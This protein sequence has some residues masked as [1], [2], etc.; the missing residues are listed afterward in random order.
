MTPDI[1]N[2]ITSLPLHLFVK[3]G[4]NVPIRTESSW[5][6]E[7][8]EILERANWLCDKVITEPEKLLKEMPAFLSEGYGGQ[9]AIYSCAILSAALL[10]ISR[11]YPEEKLLCLNRL[12]KLV[13]VTMSPEIRH[14]DT[15]AWKK[16]ALET[17]QG[18]RGHMTYLSLL[19]WTISNYKLTGGYST[20]FDELFQGCCEALSRR[21]RAGKNLCLPSFPN[22]IIFFPDMLVT[23]VALHHHD[24][25]YGDCYNETVERWLEKAKTEWIHPNTGLLLAKLNKKSVGQVPRGS[26]SALNTYY[27]SLIDPDFANQQYGR[28]MQTFAKEDLVAGKTVFGIKEYLR[29]SPAMTFDYDAGPIIS[30]FSPSGT[31]WAIGSATFSMTGR[32]EVACCVRA[33][34]QAA[35]YGAKGN[36]TICWLNSPWSAR[37]WCWP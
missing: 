37:L 11:L 16:D 23:I 28:M 15:I 36:D 22:G 34:W 17:L 21:T 25:L 13:E 32:P 24:L 4:N 20:A 9:W 12:E 5:E 29:K 26:Y 3:S 31:A 19:A 14:Y 27:L 6:E 1:L 18:N 30:G 10:N 8:T 33:R 2:T 35:R 7:K